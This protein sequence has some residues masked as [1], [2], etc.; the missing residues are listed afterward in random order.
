MN[1]Q[2]TWTFTIPFI[3]AMLTVS[4]TR[5][6][7]QC[8]G[9]CKDGQVWPY[10]QGLQGTPY[11]TVLLSE[12]E[13]RGLNWENRPGQAKET[14]IQARGQGAGTQAPTTGC[15]AR[16]TDPRA[17]VMDEHRRESPGK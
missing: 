10:P 16:N 5:L 3:Q 4:Y 17:C 8:Y 2:H 12:G 7:A 9:K 6:H 1:A 15:G 13:K 14:L 11:L